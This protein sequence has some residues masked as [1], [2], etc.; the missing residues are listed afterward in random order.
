MH[1]G[2]GRSSNPLGWLAS[3]KHIIH[4]PWIR[5]E[6]DVATGNGSC[7][8]RSKHVSLG[9]YHSCFPLCLI[10]LD[11][12]AGNDAH[13]GF[14]VYSRLAE[15]MTAMTITPER[16]YYSFDCVGGFLRKPSGAHWFPYNPNYDPGP[17]PPPKNK[18]KR[19]QPTMQVDAPQDLSRSVEIQVA[20]SSARSATTMQGPKS[21]KER[22]PNRPAFRKQR[23]RSQWS[24]AQVS[25][26]SL[27]QFGHPGRPPPQSMTDDRA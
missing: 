16:E 10:C 11:S 7:P 8:L 13:A 27:P 5:V 23:P 19:K 12:D 17:L 1:N 4:L 20:G 6:S 25:N 14:I 3:C 15:L 2:K 24:Q 21:F 22:Q 9:S 18:E 26:Q